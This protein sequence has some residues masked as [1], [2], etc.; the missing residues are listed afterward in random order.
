MD[1]I[2]CSVKGVQQTKVRYFHG[3]NEPQKR[4]NIMSEIDNEIE[5]LEVRIKH[6]AEGPAHD[7]YSFTEYSAT[8][9]NGQ[10]V[11]LHLGLMEY[12][13]LDGTEVHTQSEPSVELFKKLV[14]VDPFEAEEAYNNPRCKDHPDADLESMSG[15]PGETFA[16]CSVCKCVLECYFSESA[17][18]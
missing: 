14:G 10:I 9:K 16:I 6:G 5:K 17:I 1:G 15:Y 13:R 18:I 7:P 2:W 3:H 8:L 4:R 12:I 11:T